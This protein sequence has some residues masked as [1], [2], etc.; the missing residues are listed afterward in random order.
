MLVVVEEEIIL[1]LIY[2][3]VIDAYGGVG[4][5]GNGANANNTDGLDAT[6]YGGGG[7]GDE[8]ESWSNAGDGYQGIVAVI[9]QSRHSCGIWW[10]KNC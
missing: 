10:N 9:L 5:G 6:S 4:G 8:A 7:G 3:K 1:K 2:S